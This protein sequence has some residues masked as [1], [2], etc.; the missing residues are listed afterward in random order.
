VSNLLKRLLYYLPPILLVVVAFHQIYLAK[1]ALL[2]PWKGGG[3]GMFSSTE[4]GP[5]RT[6][7]VFVSAP[8]RSE[9]LEIPDSLAESAQKVATY[10]SKSLLKSLAEQFVARENRK[11][12]PVDSVRIEVWRTK[13]DP[14]TLKPESEKIRDYVYQAAETGI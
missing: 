11:D 13:F 4:L 3:F 9:E 8:D 12:R 1:T 10:P 5:A 14:Q 2:S 6:V 7:R